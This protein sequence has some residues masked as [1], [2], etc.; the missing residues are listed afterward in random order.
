MAYRVLSAHIAHETNTFSILRTGM[1][2]FRK[3]GLFT[4]AGVAKALTGTRTEIAA[5]ID[6][7]ARFGWDLAQPVSVAA[8]PSG[9]VTAECWE[10]LQALLFDAMDG[11]YDGVILALHGAMVTETTEDAE[12]TLLAGLRARLGEEIP[13]AVTLDLHANVTAAMAE[14]ASILL[15]YRTYPH[16][17]QYETAMRAAEFLDAAMQ[18]EVR[19]KVMRLQPPMLEGCNHGRTQGG[20]MSDL[21]ARAEELAGA[22]AAL[23]SLDI[24]AGFT[25]SD[26][27]EVGPSVLATYD[28]ARNDA[29]AAA[30]AALMS[31]RDEVWERRAENTVPEYPLAEAMARAAKPTDDARPFVI[32]D[33]SDNPGSGAYGDAVRLLEAMIASGQGSMLFGV[34]PDPEAAAACAAAGVGAEVT[35]ALGARRD[36]A[37][38]GPPVTATGVVIAV[39]DGNYVCEGPMN[40]GVPLTLGP[41]ALLRVG[42]VDVA[43]GSN[44][45]QTYDLG[46]F[47]Q[48]GAEPTDYAVIGVKSAHHFRGAFAPIA[49]EVILC[50]SG[51]LATHDLQS[52]PFKNV[53]RPIWPLDP[54]C[55]P[56]AG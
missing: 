42:N 47:R 4:G 32:G 36:P 7:A 50:D 52:L 38:Y 21:I 15:A 18:G 9:M 46:A 31:L 1:D 6:A 33:F 25:L 17:D 5:H 19:P 20:V 28:A 14:H 24:C 30:N 13:I 27:A 51:A 48:V 29:A 49:R 55:A 39:S 22:D 45:L 40:A 2:E 44:T 10:E 56:D 8:T 54:D 26:I 37:T 41:C 12:G 53:R 16:I 3:R 43:L 34:M 11:S 23:L 35:L